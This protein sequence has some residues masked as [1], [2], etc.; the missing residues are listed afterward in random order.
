ML[1][2][3]LAGFVTALT[4]LFNYLGL[5]HVLYCTIRLVISS[6]TASLQQAGAELII[7][8]RAFECRGDAVLQAQALELSMRMSKDFEQAI[9]MCVTVTLMA[10]MRETGCCLV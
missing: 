6:Q 8:C 4:A 5:R 9:S 3:L 7:N 2:P 1:R 10:I